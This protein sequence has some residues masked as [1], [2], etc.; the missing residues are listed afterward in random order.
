MLA[1]VVLTSPTDGGFRDPNNTPRILAMR[2]G[3][4]CDCGD[5]TYGVYDY[6][7]GMVMSTVDC[8]DKTANLVFEP[9][10]R[11]RKCWLYIKNPVVILVVNG[12]LGPCPCS[13]FHQT[14]HSVCYNTAQQCS[15]NNETYWTALRNQIP[16]PASMQGENMATS[17]CHGVTGT[18][19]CWSLEAQILRWWGS[20]R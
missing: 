9:N 2:M 15:A 18:H 13:L 19:V 14:I 10:N 6:N 7:T 1:L 16:G 8:G 11:P 3:K 20:P 12:V 17:Q 4:P 5:R